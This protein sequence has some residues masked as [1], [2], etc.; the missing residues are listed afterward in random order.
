[1]HEK[2]MKWEFSNIANLVE[3]ISAY[4]WGQCL[5]VVDNRR[6]VDFLGSDISAPIILQPL[7][8]LSLEVL[9]YRSSK[10]LVLPV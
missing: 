8:A 7:V 10:M 5:V 1:M 3:V 9:F 2:R 4:I 6:L